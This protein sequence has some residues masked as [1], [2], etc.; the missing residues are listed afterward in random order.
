MTCS[1]ERQVQ[2]TRLHLIQI[3]L[4]L[5]VSINC[6]SDIK[7]TMIHL[8]LTLSASDMLYG[9]LRLRCQLVQERMLLHVY[10]A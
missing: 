9:F 1:M 8:M 4:M 10:L 7:V 3:L 2:I 5:N 6:L